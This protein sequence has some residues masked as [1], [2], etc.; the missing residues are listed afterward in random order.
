MEEVEGIA[1]GEEWGCG[2][3]ET[4]GPCKQTGGEGR[5]RAPGWG[6]AFWQGWVE[7]GGSWG[8]M[9]SGQPADTVQA[10]RRHPQR[11][12]SG[13]PDAALSWK[14]NTMGDER[15]GAN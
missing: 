12:M 2:V 15:G 11:G 4:E 14:Q 1:E 7:G 13:M 5:G 9:G 3:G 6:A 10:S 8:R